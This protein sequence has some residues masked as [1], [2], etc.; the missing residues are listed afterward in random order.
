MFA[1][2][3]SDRS[4]FIKRRDSSYKERV[5]HGVVRTTVV[6]TERRSVT[7]LVPSHLVVLLGL[8]DRSR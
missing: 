7:P 2:C 1:V 6:G 5:S 3:P 8:R 4:Y